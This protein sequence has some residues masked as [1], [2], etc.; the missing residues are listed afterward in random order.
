MAKLTRQTLLQFGST[1]N[2]AS[3]IGQFG[4]YAA[5]IY[6]NVISTMQAGTAWPRG[7]VAETI[8]T[9]RPFLED[10]NTVDY[11]FGY[12][13]C[14]ILQSGI[15]EYDAGTTYFIGSVCQVAG[16]P[17]VSLTDN[18]IGNTPSASSTNWSV[19]FAQ[20]QGANVASTGTMTLGNDGN[21]FQITGTTSITSITIKPK[22]TVVRLIFQGALTLTNG[23]NLILNGNFVTAAN[24]TIEL[25]SDGTNWYEVART[26][27]S[28]TQVGLGNPSG[29][30]A[31][32][33]Y[34]A[35]TDGFVVGNAYDPTPQGCGFIIYTDS[36]ATPSTIGLRGQTLW[37]SGAPTM[38]LP[39]CCPIKKGNY[40]Q[41]IGLDLNGNVNNAKIENA[42]F[43]S[44]GS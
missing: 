30:T 20:N 3:E 40:Y 41:V 43:I 24:S 28:F 37:V 34:Q 12:M 14:Y 22:G 9:N 1:A 32:T 4:S 42:N 7:W 8:A 39:F 44:L 17:Y 15:A 23:S 16:V 35:A 13:L 38:R 11:I 19:N 27:Q 18:N 10:Q 2:P 6:T 29:K 36:T 33:I 25:L 31:G 21:S 26:P 5:P